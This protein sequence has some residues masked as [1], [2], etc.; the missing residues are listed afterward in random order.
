VIQGTLVSK[1]G[2][3]G[4]RQQRT[5]T[6]RP[7]KLNLS[8]AIVTRQPAAGPAEDRLRSQVTVGCTRQSWLRIGDSKDASMLKLLVSARS[9]PD[10]GLL[11]FPAER[12]AG[13]RFTQEATPGEL[14]VQRNRKVQD[15]LVPI[16]SSKS[17]AP[18]QT[19]PDPKLKTRDK[20]RQR[21]STQCQTVRKESTSSTRIH[22]KK[23]L[24]KE[25]ERN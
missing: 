21:C 4:G 7:D 10:E 18:D 11:A 13:R 17:R 15:D 22:K 19:E 24:Y 16:S 9:T 3:P 25:R 1:L 2:A 5:D 14:S 20:K 23:R 8:R 12:T 6:C